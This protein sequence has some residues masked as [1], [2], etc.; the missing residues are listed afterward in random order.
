METAIV[1]DTESFRAAEQEAIQLR[2]SMP[3]LCSMAIREFVQN[4]R[5]NS[6]TEQLNAVYTGYTAKIDDDILQVQ[7]DG[8]GVEDW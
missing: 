8:T 7:Y 3:A 6:I 5:K 1:L 2:V 4:R